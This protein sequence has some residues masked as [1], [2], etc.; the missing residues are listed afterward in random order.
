MPSWGLPKPRLRSWG[1]SCT[2]RLPKACWILAL[3]IAQQVVQTTLKVDPATLLAT[4]QQVLHSQPEQA[5]GANLRLYV[6]PDDEEILG[7]F[8]QALPGRADWQIITDKSITPGG[9]V[10]HTAL[11]QVDATLQTRWQRV[12]EKLKH[13]LAQYAAQHGARVDTEIGQVRA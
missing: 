10:L 2:R 11:G 1:R 9:C 7:P 8:V 6:H 3:G 4:V 5:Q 13:E 12:S